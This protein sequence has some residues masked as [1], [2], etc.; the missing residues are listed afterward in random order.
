M[1]A[2]KVALPGQR[3]PL[4][5]SNGRVTDGWYQFF[6][7]NHNRTGGSPEDKVDIAAQSGATATLAAGAANDAAGAANLAALAAQAAADAAAASGAGSSALQSLINSGVNNAC[8]IGASDAGSNATITISAN[9]R[10]YGAPGAGTNVSVSSG[11]I[12]AVAYDT[13]EYIYYDDPSRTGGA[14]TY[15]CDPD[16]LN[17]TPTPMH[18]D[19][20]YVGSVPTPAALDPPNVGTPNFYA[21]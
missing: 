11:T 19:R 2:I 15:H 12:T 7:G 3:V 6:Q 18:P 13:F 10:Y 5:D 20:H 21:P 16:P 14:V 8:T 1:T 9:T 4:V 17:A